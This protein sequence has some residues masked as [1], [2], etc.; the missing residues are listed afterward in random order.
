MAENEKGTKF[1]K[2]FFIFLVLMCVGNWG[3][4]KINA[5]QDEIARY[6]LMGPGEREV[7]DMKYQLKQEALARD[8]AY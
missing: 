4:N 3:W 1:V 8:R 7:Y 2:W 5:I 6:R